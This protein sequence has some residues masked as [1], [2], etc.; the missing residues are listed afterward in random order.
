M[1]N[2]AADWEAY[3]KSTF[4]PIIRGH[5]FFTVWRNYRLLL[6]GLNIPQGTLLEIG[7]S[8][9]LNS[10]RLAKKYDFTPTLVDTSKVALAFAKQLYRRN[11][12]T[13]N[14]INQDVMKL[15]LNQTF[16]F[17]HS[18]GLLEHFMPSFQ[19]IAFQNHAKHVKKDGWLVCWV[20]TPDILYRLSRWYLKNTGQWIFGYEKP[21]FCWL[22]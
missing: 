14:L 21:L 20:P 11:G 7:S 3:A 1:S 15:S 6:H 13:P 9:G 10:L 12:I 2:I 16:D 5:Y 17:V 8:T 4:S 19:K 18:H 22:F